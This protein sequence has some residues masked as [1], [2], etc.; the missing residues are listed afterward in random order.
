M[1]HL[2]KSYNN[3]KASSTFFLLGII[4]RL[5]F[6]LK[7]FK[8]WQMVIY[9]PPGNVSVYTL[10]LIFVALLLQNN[11]QFLVFKLEL[12]QQDKKADANNY[13]PLLVIRVRNLT[14]EMENKVPQTPFGLSHRWTIVKPREER[15]TDR[16]FDTLFTATQNEPF[17][18]ERVLAGKVS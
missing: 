3:K 2:C 7:H 18:F 8:L 17:I 13:I 1:N 5:Q 4:S 14:V 10:F 16:A 12:L 6:V 15:K 11:F 9:L